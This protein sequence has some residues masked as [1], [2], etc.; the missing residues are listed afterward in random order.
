[1]KRRLS[2]FP[3]SVTKLKPGL[4]CKTFEKDEED[5]TVLFCDLILETLNNRLTKLM[6]SNEVCMKLF[7]KGRR[8]SIHLDE[9]LSN[10]SQPKGI[11][12]S[13]I[14]RFLKIQNIVLSRMDLFRAQ[15]YINQNE[16]NFLE[17]KRRKSWSPGEDSIKN[18]ILNLR[19]NAHQS[20]V[21]ILSKKA[22][23]TLS[24]SSSKQFKLAEN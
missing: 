19:L 13:K 2:I 10:N 20:D 5:E 7:K 18:L 11:S 6:D 15:K 21:E 9:C 22:I 16:V 4:T 24:E 8:H 23:P 12:N 14:N 1:M 17:R 3:K